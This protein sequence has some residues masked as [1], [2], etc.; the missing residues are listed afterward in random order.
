MLPAPAPAP[1]AP[2]FR[3][4]PAHSSETASR[5][6]QQPPPTNA[7]SKRPPGMVVVA[8][9]AAAQLPAPAPI[10]EGA[11]RRDLCVRRWM[12]DRKMN[13]GI[14]MMRRSEAINVADLIPYVSNDRGI[15]LLEIESI[16]VE[17]RDVVA[18][19]I[20]ERRRDD[21][22]LPRLAIIEVT[23]RDDPDA[24]ARSRMLSFTIHTE[25]PHAHII[26]PFRCGVC[27]AL[28]RSKCAAL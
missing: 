16:P 27:R 11:S 18:D 9:P 21:E 12:M 17:C 3:H 14:R 8:P 19:Q 20:L 22:T 23:S 10:V 26:V 13:V 5:Q 6:Q 1:A 15:E 2:S 4:R 25:F 24:L 7:M 28:N